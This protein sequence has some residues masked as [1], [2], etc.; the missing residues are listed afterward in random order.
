[1]CILLG[2][3]LRTEH[4]DCIQLCRLTANENY[5]YSLA[6]TVVCSVPIPYDKPVT[7]KQQLVVASI[8]IPKLLPVPVIPSLLHFHF[9]LYM[10]TCDCPSDGLRDIRCVSMLD[11]LLAMFVLPLSDLSFYCTVH[12]TA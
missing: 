7:F 10:F 4:T 8:I 6:I 12:T 5:L 2:G 1:M 9:I 11:P 3:V